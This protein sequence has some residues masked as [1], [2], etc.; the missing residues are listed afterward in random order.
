MKKKVLVLGGGVL[1]VPLIK[2]AKQ[3][4]FHV[5]LADYYENPPGK[6]YCDGSRQISSNSVEDNYKYVLDEKIDYI[7]TVGADQPVYVA[8]SVSEKLNLPFP[9]NE[10][11]G[12][13]VTNKLYMKTTMKEHKI[14]TA[15]FQVFS[16]N[17]DINLQ[18]L[19]FPMVMKPVDSQG[20]RGIFV[21]TG[22][23][24]QD[25]L[26]SLFETSKGFS[27]TGSV[28][29]EEFCPGTEITVNCWVKDGKT[30]ILLITDR[31][32]FDDSIALGLC[33]QQRFPS[34]EAL[35]YEDEI[36]DTVQKLASAFDIKDG[37]LYIQ[38]V[39]SKE[40]PVIIEFGYRI[41]GGFEAD[42]IPLQTGVDIL[43]LYFTLVTEQKNIFEP[44]Q[45]ESRFQMGS[46]FFLFAKPGCIQTICMPAQ[47]KE[48]H[49]RLFVKEKQE[50]GQI[51]NATS[52]IG[53]FVIYT[54][55]PIEYK[56]LLNKFDSEMAVYDTNNND[57]LIHNIWE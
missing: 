15:K 44:N 35:I 47:F 55:N 27:I 3:K 8:A 18:N 36:Q 53:C 52:R 26:R 40:G 49:G 34:Q 43:E 31:I 32:H 33:Q 50:L 10:E 46:I 51:E 1:Q 54:N 16:R 41:G 6:K 45:M 20:Q 14:P 39:L 30:Y 4:G 56:E 42:I 38:M 28:I 12:K 24:E 13:M 25:C 57:L 7:M 48:Y 29:I 22:R 9:I 23:E 37:P 19:N 11:Q 5:L 2:M 17:E 21:L